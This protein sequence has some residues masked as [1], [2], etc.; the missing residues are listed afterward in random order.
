M[1]DKTKLPNY[2]PG[3]GVL[4]QEA[5]GTIPVLKDGDPVGRVDPDENQSWIQS[6]TIYKPTF[7]N[8]AINSNCDETI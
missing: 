8:G 5:K 4:W 3:L 7:Q 1:N 2:Y 6:Q